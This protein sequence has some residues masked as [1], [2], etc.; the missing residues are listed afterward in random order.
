MSSENIVETELFWNQIMMEHALFIRG[1]LDPTECELVETADTFAEDYF[2][3]LEE[4]KRQDCKTMNG[5]TKRTLETTKR[6][7]DFK[8]AGTKGITGCDIRSIILPLLA[9]HV[10]REANHYLR[11]LKQEGE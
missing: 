10:L 7:C 11:I 8:A 2:R 6:Y 3:L 9:D 1:L 4:A 5:L